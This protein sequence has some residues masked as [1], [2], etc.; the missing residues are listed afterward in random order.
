MTLEI[1]LLLLGL[2]FCVLIL[3]AFGG[4]GVVRPRE[5]RRRS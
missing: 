4:L 3:L 5:R 1:I 2:T